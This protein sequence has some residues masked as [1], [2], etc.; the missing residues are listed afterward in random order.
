MPYVYSQATSAHG[1]LLKLGDG[2]SPTENFTTIAEC[3]NIDGPQLANDD[4]DVTNQGSVGW[5]ESIS[6]L[7][8]GGT[9]SVELNFLPQNAT[10]SFA[11]G[12]LAH[13]NDGLRHNY[14]LVFP[15]PGA[16]T[17]TF[18]ARVKNAAPTAP[19]DGV[20]ALKVDFTITGQPTLA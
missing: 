15:D 20:L 9:V 1:T 3:K 17:W 13:F 19:V 10:Q 16:T 11:A 12:V 2:G 18:A 7:H 6:G 14:Q 4:I 8:D 5:K